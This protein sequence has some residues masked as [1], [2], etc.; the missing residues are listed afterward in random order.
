[1]KS[2]SSGDPLKFTFK[3]F[4][5]EEPSTFPKDAVDGML[6]SLKES[7]ECCNLDNLV[8][9]CLFFAWDESFGK[10]FAL[11]IFSM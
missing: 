7:A 9:V 8:E 4:L 5:M 6:L 2:K 1:M 10:C 3:A 11:N